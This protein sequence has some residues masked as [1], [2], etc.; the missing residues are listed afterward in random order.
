[1]EKEAARVAACMA[2]GA[3]ALA[4]ALATGRDA[5]AQ[6]TR[7]PAEA[8]AGAVDAANDSGGDARGAG[9]DSSG[10]VLG[11]DAAERSAGLAAFLALARAADVVLV[12]AVPGNPDHA[13]AQA[14]TV[15]ALAPAAIVFEA[16]PQ[17]R[18]AELN[19]LREQGADAARL[20]AASGAS[21]TDFA[22]IAAIM[23]AAPR[24]RVFGAGQ[25]AEDVAEA[26]AEG[27]AAAFG[28]DAAIYGI[29]APPSDA[30]AAALAPCEPPEAEAAPGGEAAEAAEA[31]LRGR[32]EAMRF[33]EA[34]LADATIWAR[35]MTGDAQV[36]VIAGDAAVDKARGAAAMIAR[37]EP[38]ARIAALAQFEDV[39]GPGLFDAT[40]VTPAPPGGAADPCAR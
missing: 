34:G 5:A 4:G 18:E 17:A 39:E 31:A 27:A 12:G 38:E 28:P 25:P 7:A 26:Q 1:M 10:D 20:A 23:A 9:G 40:L 8:A 30:D 13:R 11:A 36:V 16:I 14:E 29:D 3:L 37:A 24:A 32:I 21:E 6:A 33:R 35:L 15:A 19:A 22:P 2:L